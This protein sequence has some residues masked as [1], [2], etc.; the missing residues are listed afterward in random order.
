MKLK[1]LIVTIAILAVLSAAAFWANRPETHAASDPRVDKTV[2]DS[3]VVDKAAKIRL[4]DQGKTVIVERLADGTWRDD[5]YYDL[6]ADFTKLSSFVGDL[7]S[8]KIQRVVTTNPGRIARLDFKDTKIELLDS[9]DKPI[10]TLLL[11]KNADMGGRFVQYGD[12][13]KAYLAG[14]TAY[15]DTDPKN[16]ADAQLLN[17][18]PEDVAKIEVPFD[19]SPTVA[20][21]REKKDGAWTASP[22]PAGQQVKSDKVS[23]LLTSLGAIR[24]SD[25]TDSADAMAG[26]AK[27][28][29]RVFKLTTFDGKTYTIAMGRKPEEKKLKPVEKKPEAPASE[30]K[31][32]AGAPASPASPAGEAKPAAEKPPEPEYDTIPAGPVFAWISSTDP[33]AAV[34]SLMQKRS[35][36]VDDYTFTGLPQKSDELFEPAPPPPAPVKKPEGKAN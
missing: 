10:F 4:T 24:F 35:F 16:W 7:T 34:N 3:S 28:H 36:Q 6:P 33:K 11:G 26:V 20:I 17:V 22:T 27:K 32:A 14:L 15:M 12:E 18:K 2:V 13:P 31:P 25:T 21:S 23:S 1:T 9:S 30:A 8:A 5:S 29:E 19:Q